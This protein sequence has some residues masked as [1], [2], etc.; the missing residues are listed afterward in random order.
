MRIIIVGAGD[1]GWSLMAS[2]REQGRD[3]VVVIDS[4]EKRCEQVAAEFDALVLTGDGTAPEMLAKAKIGDADALV[5]TTGSDPI[6]TVV[7]M[8]GRQNDVETIIVKLKGA[9]LRPACQEIGVSRIVS[10]SISAAAEIH[11]MLGGT[12][13]LDFSVAARGDLR[14]ADLDVGEAAGGALDRLDLPEEALVV[15]V[16]RNDEAVFPRHDLKL[17]EGDVLLVLV[18]DESALDEVR[19]QVGGNRQSDGDDEGE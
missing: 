6:N 9:G 19:D 8:L 12:R 11:S 5:A 17:H 3:D 13:R 2:L 7:A 16:L 18:A 10:P 1:I 14:L 15:A 4:D